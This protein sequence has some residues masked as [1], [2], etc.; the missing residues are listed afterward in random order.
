MLGGKDKQKKY[1]FVVGVIAVIAIVAVLLINPSATGE[2]SRFSFR[3]YVVPSDVS[4][5]PEIEIQ[6]IDDIAYTEPPIQT[7]KDSD[8]GLNFNKKGITEGFSWTGKKYIP[9]K[10]EDYC[11]L[12]T[13]GIHKV[14][15]NCVAGYG[16]SCRIVESACEN[17]LVESYMKECNDNCF[18]G[19]CQ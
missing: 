12:L 18:Q 14:V 2:A 1:V 10:R 5:Q 17:D 3:E 6:S 11:V 8:F 15:D 16:S 19:A 13:N 4:V 9:V 7:C